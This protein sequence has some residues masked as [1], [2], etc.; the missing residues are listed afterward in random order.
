LRVRGTWR[1]VLLL[2]AVLAAGGSAGCAGQGSPV[3]C[4]P[5]YLAVGWFV[6]RAPEALR[7]DSSAPAGLRCI[8]LEGVGLLLLPGRCNLGYV[9]T[10]RVA[11]PAGCD[12]H[13]RLSKLEVF[14]GRQAELC[15][16]GVAPEPVAGP[17]LESPPQ[18]TL[19]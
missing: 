15:A 1:L 3:A 6:R 16:A 2:V 5:G 10:N 12:A 17:I 7:T 14:T 13:V 8:D 9:R 18:E 11:V 19:P 4:G